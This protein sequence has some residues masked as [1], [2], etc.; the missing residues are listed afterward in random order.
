MLSKLAHNIMAEE[1]GKTIQEET[2]AQWETRPLKAY[3]LPK[4]TASKATTQMQQR[5]N[6]LVTAKGQLL[7]TGGRALRCSAKPCFCPIPTFCE[8]LPKKNNA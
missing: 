4:T 6:A 7:G 8:R 5:V 1:L 2:T 3:N